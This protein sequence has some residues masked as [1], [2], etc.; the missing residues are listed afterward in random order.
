LFY[1]ILKKIS[2]IQFFSRIWEE[3]KKERGERGKESGMGGDGGGD[4]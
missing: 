1:T 3:E 2:K 4:V